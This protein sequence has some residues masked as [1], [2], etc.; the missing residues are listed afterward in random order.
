MINHKITTSIY[1]NFNYNNLFPKIF[2]LKPK[3]Y[4]Q[5]LL[6][7]NLNLDVNKNQAPNIDIYWN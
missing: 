1:E 2:Q 7:F 4:I 3:F 5:L 6:I